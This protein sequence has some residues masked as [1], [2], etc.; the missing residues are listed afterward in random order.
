MSAVIDKLI[1]DL[2]EKLVITSVVVTH[3]MRSVFTI[4]DRVIMLHKGKVIADGYPEEIRNSKDS[5]LQQFIKGEPEG[6]ISFVQNSDDYLKDL[7][8]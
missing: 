4:A 7:L 5:L 2:T 3:D 8:T 1:K 6:P